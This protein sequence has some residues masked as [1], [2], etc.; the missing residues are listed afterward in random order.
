MVGAAMIDAGMLN[1]RRYA[2]W[3]S[4]RHGARRTTAHLLYEGLVDFVGLGRK[5]RRCPPCAVMPGGEQ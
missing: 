2:P 4:E 5:M 1:V 3:C